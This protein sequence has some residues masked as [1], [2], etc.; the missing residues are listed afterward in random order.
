[1]YNLDDQV[2]NAVF[3]LT[4]EYRKFFCV[5]KCQ[6]NKVIYFLKEKGAE[7]TPLFLEDKV[8]ED[9]DP[10]TYYTFLPVWCHPRFV[11]FF[12]ENESEDI[13]QNYEVVEVNLDLFNQQWAP[14]LKENKIAL[15]ILPLEKD[16]DFCI[17][18]ADFLAE[19]SQ[20][21]E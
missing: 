8:Q 10:D 20:K 7:G 17:E 21:P 5:Q 13:K 16:K 19:T 11:E 3:N 6:E 15:A 2:Y 4:D 14:A 18:E 12:L 9:D 1:M